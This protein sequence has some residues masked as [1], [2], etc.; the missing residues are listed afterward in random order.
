MSNPPKILNKDGTLS[1]HSFSIGWKEIYKTKS[2]DRV[3][4]N[5]ESNSLSPFR[6]RLFIGTS[7]SFYISFERVKEARDFARRHAKFDHV[8]LP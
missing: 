5:K 2:G 4:I 7:R 1:K 3:V 6:V 8:K